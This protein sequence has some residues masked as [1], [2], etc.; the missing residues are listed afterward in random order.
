MVESKETE[1][2]G[3]AEI[4]KPVCRGCFVKSST[5]APKV[6]Y[7]AEC[8]VFKENINTSN[9]ISTSTE[10]TLEKK[11]PVSKGLTEHSTP[12]VEDTEN[13]MAD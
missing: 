7:D 12:L 9:I 4:Y 13:I 5:G 10:G 1:L 8:D 6:I 3:G 2:I 11:S